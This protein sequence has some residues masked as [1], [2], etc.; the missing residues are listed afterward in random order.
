MSQVNDLRVII[1]ELFL[2]INKLLAYN[3]VTRVKI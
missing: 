1:F 2:Y 3:S